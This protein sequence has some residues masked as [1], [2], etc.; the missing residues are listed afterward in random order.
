MERKEYKNVA[1]M[2][3]DVSADAA[4]ARETQE[5]IDKRFIVHRLYGSRSA[6]GV[7]QQE[8]AERLNCSQS[9]IS[10]LENSEDEDLRLGDL[11]RYL[12]A[13]GMNLTVF[14]SK[15]QWRSVEQ[16]KFHAFRIRHI[17]EHLT[18]LAKDDPEIAKGV[19]HCHVE[20]LYN[21]VMLVMDSAQGLPDFPQVLPP[22]IEADGDEDMEATAGDR[23]RSRAEAASVAGG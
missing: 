2:I 4:F 13:I 3:A 9:R 11:K 17:L 16:I 19:Q 6:K 20:T 14:I 10:K 22:L 7:S 8:M 15:K 12:D 1:E 23:K 21:L 5:H 18:K